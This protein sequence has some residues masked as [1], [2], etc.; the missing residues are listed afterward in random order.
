MASKKISSSNTK[1]EK[2]Q[3]AKSGP[4]Q[5]F[6]PT[7]PVLQENQFLVRITPE[8]NDENFQIDP[9]FKLPLRSEYIATLTSCAPIARRKHL[10]FKIS[11]FHW[12]TGN[13]KLSPVKCKDSTGI[14]LRLEKWVKWKIFYY[15]EKSSHVFF[16]FKTVICNPSS[17]LPVSMMN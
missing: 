2:L 10:F 8:I 15:E 13:L 1:L 7:S 12:F 3:L 5:P 14:Y 17:V 9:Y 11:Y 6:F 16:H 4:A